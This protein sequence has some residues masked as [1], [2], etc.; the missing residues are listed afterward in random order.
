MLYRN[1]HTSV[2]LLETLLEDI[3]ELVQI[4]NKGADTLTELEVSHIVLEIIR[5]NVFA[6]CYIP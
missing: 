4:T 1:R 6:A 5:L 2:I 3:L